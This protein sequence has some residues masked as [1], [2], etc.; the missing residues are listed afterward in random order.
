MLVFIRFFDTY[1]ILK[2]NSFSF[3]LFLLELSESHRDVMGAVKAQL[4]TTHQDELNEVT[5]SFLAETAIKVES[6]RL[7]TET[8]YQEK[9]DAMK[10]KHEEELQAMTEKLTE[11]S[12][13]AVKL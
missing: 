12:N 13:N 8:E 3:L 4:E 5:A 7:E 2:G 11:V 6:A 9:L 10:R 1:R